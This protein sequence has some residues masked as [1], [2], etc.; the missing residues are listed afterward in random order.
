MPPP[1][2]APPEQP[3]VE[4]DEEQRRAEAEQERR[5][6]T[7]AF[8]DRFGVIYAVADTLRDRVH[9]GGTWS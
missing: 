7:A 1:C 9:E 8:L 4:A 2:C 3:D 6:R 5:P